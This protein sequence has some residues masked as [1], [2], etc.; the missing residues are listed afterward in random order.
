M[1]TVTEPV[2][3]EIIGERLLEVRQG[4]HDLKAD[5]AKME[6]RLIDRMDA[7]F[8]GI[9]G[10]LDEITDRLSN[11]RLRVLT[12]AEYDALDP[13]DPNTVYFISG[14]K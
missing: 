7:R 8:D 1:A 14:D 6:D 11:L 12:Q 2:T 4:L 3:L 10:R 5:M 9:D 13:P